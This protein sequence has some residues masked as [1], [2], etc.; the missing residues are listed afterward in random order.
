MLINLSGNVRLYRIPGGMMKKM[1][2][3]TL[4]ILIICFSAYPQEKE[5]VFYLEFKDF[6]RFL[7][8]LQ[9]D[10]NYQAFI[11]SS[12]FK[13]YKNTRLGL[14]FPKRVKIFEDILEFSLSFKNI[15]TISGKETSIWLFDIG[16]LKLLFI[17]RLSKSDY[18]KSRLA[19][20]RERFGEARI[21]TVT[22]YFKKDE[23]GNKEVD[24]AFIKGNLILSNEPG[25]FEPFLRRLIKDS[26][27]TKW[28]DNDFLAWL[29]KPVNKDYDIFIYLS[30]ES[31][32][33]T[34]FT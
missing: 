21:D 2:F 27:F 6:S 14:K 30:P 20:S 11:E 32:R 17:T 7:H 33:N 1:F 25:E 9:T 28:K 5:P 19:R 26:N 22:Y 31:I 13:W 10:K 15:E 24:F 18:L 34:Y 23:S 8:N 16:E 29:D 3:L 12:V 4:F